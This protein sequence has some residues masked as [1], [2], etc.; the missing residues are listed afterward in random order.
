MIRLINIFWF[1]I[2]FEFGNNRIWWDISAKIGFAKWI[3]VTE[4]LWIPFQ[5][6]INSLSALIPYIHSYDNY[7][8]KSHVQ[9]E[10]CRALNQCYNVCYYGVA[11]LIQWCCWCVVLL[12][13]H[14][15]NDV[16]GVSF[17]LINMLSM[18]LLVCRSTW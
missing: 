10:R 7:N 11:G 17:Y 2:N 9:R 14:A 16:V 18:M 12:D 3:Q 8:L 1:W 15:F 13:K 5:C 4:S 6:I